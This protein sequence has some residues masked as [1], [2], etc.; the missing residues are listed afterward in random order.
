MRS[1]VANGVG[2]SLVNVRARSAHSLDG[3]RIVNV[4]LRGQHRPMQLGLAWSDS[5]KLRHVVEVF[6]QRCRSFI[7][8]EYIPGMTPP[9]TGRWVVA[10]PED[11]PRHL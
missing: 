4:Q 3:K 11:A 10:E 2:Y 9:A 7:S 8:N 5:D 6:M 1:L